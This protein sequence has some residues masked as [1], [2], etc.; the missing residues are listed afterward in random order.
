MRFMGS[1]YRAAHGSR[2]QRQPTR[3]YDELHRPKR[4]RYNGAVIACYD[5]MVQVFSRM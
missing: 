3:N 1:H 4:K 2:K 5:V